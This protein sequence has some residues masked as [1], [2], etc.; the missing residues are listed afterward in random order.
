M[1]KKLFLLLTGSAIA[2]FFAC[3][4]EVVESNGKADLTLTVAVQDSV[5]GVLLDADVSLNGGT[6]QTAKK[7][8]AVFNDVNTGTHVLLVKKAEYAEMTVQTDVSLKTGQTAEIS[9]DYF[10]TIKLLPLTSGL[11]GYLSYTDEN[12]TLRPAANIEVSLK[13]ND[14]GTRA[15]INK[16]YSVKTDASGKYSFEKL[17]AVG[18]SYDIWVPATKIGN[19]SYGNTSIASKPNLETG[20]TA[21]VATTTQLSN[22]TNLFIVSGYNA[23]IEFAKI[24]EPIKIT[25]TEAVNGNQFNVSSNPSS[26]ETTPANIP[27]TSGWNADNTELTLTPAFSWRGLEAVVLNNF[28]SV[29]GR[30]LPK[31]GIPDWSYG[32]DTWNRIESTCEADWASSYSSR[33]KYNRPNQ[34]NSNQCQYTNLEKPSLKLTF[35]TISSAADLSQTAAIVPVVLTDLAKINNTLATTADSSRRVYFKFNKVPGATDYIVY[36]NNND[37]GVYRAVTTT[38]TADSIIITH[39]AETENDFT[40][41]ITIGNNS[42]FREV[43]ILVQA[44]NAYSKTPIDPTKAI[45]VKDAIKPTGTLSTVITDIN[46]LNYGQKPGY[47]SG[48]DTLYNGISFNQNRF[49]TEGGEPYTGSIG[50]SEPIQFA[51]V[52]LSLVNTTD[53]ND[54]AFKRLSVEPV[55]SSSTATTL[56]YRIKFAGGP[57]LTSNL[58]ARLIVKNIKDLTGNPFEVKY[59]DG[60]SPP[61]LIAGGTKDHITIRLYTAFTFAP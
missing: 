48:T 20:R 50:F 22:Q 28:K 7:G 59:T 44:T 42:L 56:Y 15:F 27:F 39:F 18:A 52:E 21:Y 31:G 9:R 30:E 41:F 38:R 46:S 2:L 35:T 14:A 61:V 32:F 5:T 13:L 51:N 29:S 58:E 34:S 49:Q 43:G 16:L 6:P 1:N 23:L 55:W 36:A 24:N 19:I 10:Q 25:F 4:G 40:K 17:P 11:Y 8:V 26:I 54:A 53:G 60:A 33:Y 3:S 45:K 37:N 47:N 12:G 57:A